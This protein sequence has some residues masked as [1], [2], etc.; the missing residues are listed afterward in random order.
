MEIINEA[1][2]KFK[3]KQDEICNLLFGVLRELN[4]LEKEIRERKKELERK[5]EELGIEKSQIAPGASELFDE[6]EERYDEIIEPYCTDKF[7]EKSE[8]CSFGYPT[9]Y[10]YIDGECTVNFIM[11]TAARAVVETHFKKGIACNKH[12]FVIRNVDGKWLI[13]AVYDGYEDEPGKWY[14]IEL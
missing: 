13:D 12:K 9:R 4:A 3:D 1:N 8:R 10:H 5:K 6:Y 11:K 14:S 2:D 7:Y